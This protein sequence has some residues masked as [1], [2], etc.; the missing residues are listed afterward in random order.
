M[1]FLANWGL[2]FRLVGVSS[3]TCYWPSAAGPLLPVVV[4]GA[5]RAPVVFDNGNDLVVAQVPRT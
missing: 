1:A 2:R 5:I 4:E 3:F